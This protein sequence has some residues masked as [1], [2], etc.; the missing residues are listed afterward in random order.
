MGRG[1]ARLIEDIGEGEGGGRGCTLAEDEE[2]GG[3]IKI[4]SEVVEGIKEKLFGCC[5]T[6]SPR[7][8]HPKSS[9]Q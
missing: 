9:K 8:L 6:K 5:G 2:H 4:M 3:V 7:G 1:K